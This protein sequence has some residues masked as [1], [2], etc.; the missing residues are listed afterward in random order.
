MK[1]NQSRPAGVPHPIAVRRLPGW[2]PPI[3]LLSLCA[4]PAWTGYRIYLNDQMT[5]AVGAGDTPTAARYLG[6]G[7]D[8]AALDASRQPAVYTATTR[9]DVALVLQR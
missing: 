6:R 8:P 2:L 1:P 3:V 5:R 4:W 9:R 7:A